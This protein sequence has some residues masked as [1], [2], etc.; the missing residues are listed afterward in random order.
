[1]ETVASMLPLA[2]NPAVVGIDLELLGNDYEQL[3]RLFFGDIT[4]AYQRDYG[5]QAGGSWP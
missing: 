5:D 4:Q 1:M 2:E 3:E